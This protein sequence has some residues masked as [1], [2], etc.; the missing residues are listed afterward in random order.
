[1]SGEIIRMG[2]PTSHGGK[3]I[4]GSPVDICHGKPISS[5]GHQTYCPQCKGSFPIIEGVATTTFYGRG[6]ALAGMKTACGAV[7]IATQFTDTVE[8][9]G[10]SN[11]VREDSH[12]QNSGIDTA[13]PR[14]QSEQSPP[15]PAFDLFFHAKHEATGK[16]IVNTPYKITFDDGQTFEGVTDANGHTEKVTSDSPKFATI[17]IPYYDNSS[18][19]PD[20]GSQ[21]C[22]C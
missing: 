1:M 14:T 9:G 19:Y 21:P 22:G 12:R 20:D 16:S 11:A 2:D 4:E 8:Y 15:V 5:I 6:V 10:G 7:L 17:E 3:V 18:A 13:S